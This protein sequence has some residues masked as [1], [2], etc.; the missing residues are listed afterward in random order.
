MNVYNLFGFF[1]TNYNKS[2]SEKIKDSDRI[3]RISKNFYELEFLLQSGDGEERWS[4]PSK[5]KME[6]LIVDMLVIYEKYCC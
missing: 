6:E 4:I 1:I 2:S 3:K 5:T